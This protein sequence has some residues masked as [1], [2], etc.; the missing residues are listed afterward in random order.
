MCITVFL[1]YSGQFMIL[2]SKISAHVNDLPVHTDKQYQHMFLPAFSRFQWLLR[3]QL[4]TYNHNWLDLDV[5][6]GMPCALR[7]LGRI[8]QWFDLNIR[9]ILTHVRPIIRLIF[10]ST[11]WS[12]IINRYPFSR[13][14]I[15]EARNYILLASYQYVRP[16]SK[17]VIN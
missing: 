10:I 2:I 13:G 15:Q 17:E 16:F 3:V 12:R 6:S 7:C 1:L 8:G 9:I 14:C 5:S 4:E 11:W